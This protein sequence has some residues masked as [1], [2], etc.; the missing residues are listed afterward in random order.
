MGGK[1]KPPKHRQVRALPFIP[2]ESELDQLISGANKKTATFLQLLKETAMRSG[3]AWRLEWTDINIKNSTITL[4]E[5]E[6]Y[7]KP[8]MFKISTKLLAMLQEMP[9]TSDYIFE[10]NL[11]HIS[12]LE[13]HHR[14]P[15]NQRHP[16]RNG[17]AWP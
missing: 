8:R 14:I 12:T 7:G 11:S 1:W 10:G 5:P 17:N 2:L 9:K 6:K 4:N 16:A 3:E 15:Q 13:S